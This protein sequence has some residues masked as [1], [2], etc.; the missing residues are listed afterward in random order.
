[1]A[2]VTTELKV[3]VKAVGKGEVDK[4]SKS[5]NDLGSK[6]AAPANRQFRELSVELKKIQRNSTQSIANLRGYRNAWRDISEQVKIGSREFKIATENARRLDAQLQKAQGRGRP[7]GFLGRI[8]GV[9]G[10]AK[11]VGAIAA[12]GVFGGPEGAL[13]AGIGLAAGG[14]AGA[15]VGAAIGAQVGGIRQALGATA[16]YSANLDK[17]RIALKGVTTSSE[18]YQ[19]GLNFVQ[20]STERFAIPQEVLTRQF[21]KL[22]ASVQG[23]GGNLDDTKTAFNGIVAAVR[24]TGGSLADV[25]AALT[26]TAQVFSK[27]KVSAEE[28]RQ[29]IG[30]RL[31]GAFT[32]F[33]ESMGLTPAEL[34]KALEQGKVSLQDFQGFAKAIFERYGK[35]AEAIAKS[36]KA[37]GDQLQV[38]LQQL[39]E[40]VGRLLQPIGAFFQQT[41]G[42]IVKDINRAT[43]ALARF[44]NLSFDPEK[45][46]AAQATF[47]R[48]QA[49]LDDPSVKGARRSRAIT[50]RERARKTIQQQTRLRDA[51]AVD[52]QQPEAAGGFSP[53]DLTGGAANG[54]KIKTTSAD[55]LR[56]TEKRFE[57]FRDGN[58]EIAADFARQIAEQQALEDFNNKKIDA[59]TKNVRILKAQE[60]FHKEILRLRERAKNGE[61]EYQAE[62]TKTQQLVKNI[63]LTFRDNMAQGISDVILKARSLGD[64]LSNVLKMAAN[65]FIQFGVKT[66]FSA[67]PGFDKIIGSANGNVFYQNKVVPFA[68]GGIVNQPTIFPMANGAGLMGEAGPEA[69]MP[70]RR[71]PSGRLGVEA[72]GGA[73][74]NVV[75]NVDASGSAVQG[76]SNQAAQLG[77]AIGSAV[78]AE[79][80]KQ[81]RP[82]G[83]LAGV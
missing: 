42:A 17:L 70:L 55:I 19:E 29:Q 69:I 32:L 64:V 21:T 12:G 49:L 80:I 39:Q 3:L 35:N 59:N 33:A 46:E 41:F 67:I 40:S 71:G 81:K 54:Q 50:R 77:K 30:E 10:A 5:L 20:E 1:M 56:L 2:A 45:L 65:L 47:D 4:L 38:Q 6:A 8:G 31:P 78:Q 58:A 68:R 36:P 18:E 51:S 73:G 76:D 52:V 24:A 44:L 62:L 48:A 15:A 16:E 27:G 26:A 60:R 83:L 43:N 82:G 28:L 72:A 57:A 37:A 22:Q 79:L 25:D 74:G 7:T 13:G 63:A 9:K 66:M 14:P 75:V 61:T 23:A 11:G 53:L 34:D